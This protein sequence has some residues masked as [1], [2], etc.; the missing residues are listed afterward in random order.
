M[1]RILINAVGMQDPFNKENRDGPIL[2]AIPELKPDEIYFIYTA[3]PARSNTEKE[4]YDT[5]DELLKRTSANVHL[6][7]LYLEN[8]SDYDTVLQKFREI[9]LEFRELTTEEELAVLISSGIP[10]MQ[11]C[12]A[13]LIH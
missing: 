10:A 8:P 9:A 12:W 13:I 3:P 1:K 11:A 6:C 2:T 7:S 4:V 5:R